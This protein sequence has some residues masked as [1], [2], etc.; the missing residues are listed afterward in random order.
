[1]IKRKRVIAVLGTRPE[2]T[3]TA[4]LIRHI[5]KM[6]DQ[7]PTI[8]VTMQQ[9]ALVNQTIQDLA[10]DRFANLVY[11]AVNDSSLWQESCEKE[12]DK[13]LNGRE[14]DLGLIQG[15]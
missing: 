14:F 8:I 9:G 10:I 1:M 7:K 11:M 15:D 5:S 3:K 6:V 13:F 12:I 4:L 2:F